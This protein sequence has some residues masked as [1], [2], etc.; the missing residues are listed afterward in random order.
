M[1]LLKHRKRKHPRHTWTCPPLTQ[2]RTQLPDVIKYQPRI[3][4]YF[5]NQSRKYGPGWTMTIPFY[6]FVDISKPEWIQYA[7]KDN[8]E[9]YPKVR[10]GPRRSWRG[11]QWS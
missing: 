7:Q 3:I 6:R 11:V 8:F 9:N 2:E 1:R 10:L 4:E 5:I